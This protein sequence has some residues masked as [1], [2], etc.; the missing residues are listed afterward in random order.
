MIVVLDRI[1]P[2]IQ[3]DYCTHGRTTCIGGCGN[4][5]WLGDKTHDVVADGLAEPICRECAGRLIP[6][7]TQPV[8]HIT[9]RR[10]T[11][12]PH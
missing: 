12:G 7:D 10:R 1:E 5:L 3:P 6:P 2:G 8:D 4:W 11:E 9:D